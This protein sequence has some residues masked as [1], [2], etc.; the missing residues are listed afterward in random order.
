MAIPKSEYEKMLE[1][2]LAEST[3]FFLS[4]ERSME[5][6]EELNKGMEEFL[7]KEKK[8]EVES[9]LELTSIILNA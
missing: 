2:I 3:E 6:F 8:I 5:V 7:N 4:E 9:E 1:G